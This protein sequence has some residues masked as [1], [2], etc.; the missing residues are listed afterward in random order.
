MKTSKVYIRDVTAVSKIAILLFGGDLKVYQTH[1]VVAVDE[2]L[3]F[4][5]GAKQA[6]LIKHL[7]ELFSLT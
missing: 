5:V 6:T 3:K 2:W 7:T 4:K 1:G